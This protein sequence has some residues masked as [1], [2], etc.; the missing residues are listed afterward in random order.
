MLIFWSLLLHV[1][2]LCPV[3]DPFQNSFDDEL[4][5][6]VC[7]LGRELIGYIGSKHKRMPFAAPY[8]RCAIGGEFFHVKG[9]LCHERVNCFWLDS[10]T[11][12][13]V[14]YSKKKRENDK[15]LCWSPYL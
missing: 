13:V 5:P 15:R 3:L 12:K 6:V 8:S 11:F 4:G 14:K 1:Y 2:F 9:K 10:P 7:F